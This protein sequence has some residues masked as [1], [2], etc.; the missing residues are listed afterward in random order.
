M[1][2]SV[3]PTVARATPVLRSLPALA[4]AACASASG[5]ASAN[6]PVE[7]SRTI[8]SSTTPMVNDLELVRDNRLAVHRTTATPDKVWATLPGALADLGLGGGPL[9]GQARAWVASVPSVRRQLNKVLLSRYLECGTTSSGAPGAD[10]HLI[11]L[12]VTSYVEPDGQGA[13]VRTQVLARATSV[14]GAS[15]MLDCSTTGVLEARIYELLEARLR[16][17]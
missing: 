7:Q 14:E 1:R 12:Q 2:R 9:P 17:P 16:N 3:I 10:T 8:I 6:P 11:R 13:R 15:G 4:L 5:G